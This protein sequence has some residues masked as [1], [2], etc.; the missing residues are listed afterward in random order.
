M[1]R[2]GCEKNQIAIRV[3]QSSTLDAQIIWDIDKN[4]EIEAIDHPKEDSVV[5][6]S[7]GSPYIINEDGLT[8]IDQGVNTRCYDVRGFTS[9]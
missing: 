2:A 5:F 1:V 8:I 6:D 7:N 9:K 4:V 3:R